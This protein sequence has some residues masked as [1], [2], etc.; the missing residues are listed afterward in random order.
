[1]NRKECELYHCEYKNISEKEFN[2]LQ[3]EKGREV[4]FPSDKTQHIMAFVLKGEM[5]ITYEKQ[6]SVEAYSPQVFVVPKRST[7]KIKVSE[8]TD[9][10]IFY[11]RFTELNGFCDKFNIKDIIQDPDF[12]WMFKTLEMKEP[13][14]KY[15]DYLSY[16]PKNEF[17]QYFNNTHKKVI[18]SIFFSFYTHDE[19][20][21]LFYPINAK[22]EYFKLLVLKNYSHVKNLRDFAEKT[23]CSLST[24]KRRFS[25]SFGMP[26]HRWLQIRKSSAIKEDLKN[27]TTNFQEISERYG[28]P[29]Q[30]HLYNFCVR[31]LGGSPSSIRNGTENTN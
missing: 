29:S 27:H 31:H 2:Y 18:G 25:E 6:P 30:K 12:L 26:A 3:Y 7:I 23:G 4:I 28:F 1:M 9:S 13:L 16:I 15:I 24:F 11:M 8:K 14:S 5:T 10:L 21:Q 17:C 19:L 22:E 20:L